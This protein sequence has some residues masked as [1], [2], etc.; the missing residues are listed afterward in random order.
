V[1]SK[2]PSLGN[3]FAARASGRNTVQQVARS[4][5]QR[6]CCSIADAFHTRMVR[7]MSTAI[8]NTSSFDAVPNNVA[9]AVLTPGRHGV[10]RTFEAVE[11][12]GPSR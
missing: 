10:N 2:R 5:R 7:A 6:L 9:L 3:A 8:D 4:K 1:T 11:C 12:H